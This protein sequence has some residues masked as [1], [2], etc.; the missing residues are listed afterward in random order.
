MGNL[1]DLEIIAQASK[2]EIEEK[3]I[4][5]IKDAAEGGGYILSGTEAGIYRPKWVENFLIISEISKKYRY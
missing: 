5:C 4:S 3:A 2:E 1:D